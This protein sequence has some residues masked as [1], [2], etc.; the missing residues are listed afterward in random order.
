MPSKQTGIAVTAN[1]AVRK[2]YEEL[3]I[4]V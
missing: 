3:E 4:H 1:K 2:H